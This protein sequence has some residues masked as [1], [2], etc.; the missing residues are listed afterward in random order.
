MGSKLSIIIFIAVVLVQVIAGIAQSGQKKKQKERMR[1]AHAM[2]LGELKNQVAND[3]LNVA[4]AIRAET[5][6]IRRQAEEQLRRERKRSATYKEKCL[7][8]HEREKRATATLKT[9]SRNQAA[10]RVDAMTTLGAPAGEGHCGEF[11]VSLSSTHQEVEPFH[12]IFLFEMP[13]RAGDRDD[14]GALHCRDTGRSWAALSEP[15]LVD[16]E[17]RA[18]AALLID[19]YLTASGFL[20]AE[21]V[22]FTIAPWEWR[23]WVRVDNP[24]ADPDLPFV[25]DNTEQWYPPMHEPADAAERKALAGVMHGAWASFA[26][27]GDPQHEGLPDWRPYTRPNRTTLRIGSIIEPVSDLAGLSSPKRPWPASIALPTR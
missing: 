2:A 7:A 10:D 22:E 27:N 17:W 23:Q 9:V 19:E 1:E 13:P 5:E 15:A 18:A 11:R 14:D 3:K 6:N 4:A 8:A 20:L 24:D 26:R 12:L 25:F 16:A 21:S